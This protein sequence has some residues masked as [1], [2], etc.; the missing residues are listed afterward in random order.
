MSYDFAVLA[1]E[2]AGGD[3]PAVLAAAAAVFEGESEPTWNAD[4][5]WERVQL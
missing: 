3:D 1:P 5:D 4:A 2:A